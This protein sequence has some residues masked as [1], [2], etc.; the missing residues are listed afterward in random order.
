MSR[1]NSLFYTVASLMGVA[2]TMALL[3]L[4]ASAASKSN[5]TKISEAPINNSLYSQTG[6]ASDGFGTQM[7][8]YPNNNTVTPNGQ[9][10]NNNT[11]QGY[12]NNNTVTPN[13]QNLNNNTNQGYPNNNTVTPNGQNLNNNTNQGYP[14]NN[15]VTPNGQNLDNTGG[16]QSDPNFNNGTNGSGVN[17]NT[18]SGSSGQGVRALW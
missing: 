18:G 6:G 12:P 13:G 3:T 1:K 15:T 11:N 9:N 8:G 14:N 5:E 10:L 2:G 4:P 7:Q 16:S 17:N